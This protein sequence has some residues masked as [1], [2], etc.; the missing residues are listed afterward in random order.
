MIFLA[1]GIT[2]AYA[3]L[4]IWLRNGLKTLPRKG[5][6]PRPGTSPLVSVIVA[7]RNEENT[8]GT[9]LKDAVNQDYPGDRIEIIVVNDHSTDGTGDR[10]ESFSATYPFVHHVQPETPPPGWSPKKWALRAGVARSKGEILL[11]TDADCSLPREWISTMVAPFRDAYTGMVAGPSPMKKNGGIWERTLMLDSMGQDALAAGGLSRGIP[12]TASGR[13]L[14]IRRKA[15]DK[16]QGYTGIESLF[17][18]DDDLMMH[19]VASG[20]WNLTFCLTSTAEASSPPPP[21][22]VSFVRQRLRFASKGRTYFLLP[23]VS[24]KFRAI[25][26]LIF[27]TNLSVLAGQI[28]FLSTLQS[29]WLLPLFVK[30]LSDG[31]LLSR[32]LGILDQPLFPGIFLVTEVWHSLYVTI[33]GLL[34]S[35]FSVTWKGRKRKP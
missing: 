29:V 1:A 10:V 28:Q 21:D 34:G 11:L 22:L 15:F 14:A 27:L 35:F 19:K 13:N 33:F 2:M 26:I 6:Q 8:I 20:G 12:L 3:V 32:Y 18:G 7:A 23:F 4:L 16:I 30:I 24:G 5:D 31:L 17:S 9:L 25:L